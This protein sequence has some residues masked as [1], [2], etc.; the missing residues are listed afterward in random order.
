NTL[1][2]QCSLTL[3]DAT[4]RRTVDEFHR[5]IDEPRVRLTEIVDGCH[6][7]VIDAAR[8]CCL[9]IEAAHHVDVPHHAG[10]H[11][12]ER[13]PPPHLHVLGEKD[14]PH[15]ALAELLEHLIAVC[16]DGAYELVESEVRRPERRAV[17]LTEARGLRILGPALRAD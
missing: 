5:E 1:G 2:C 7:G 16:D 4:H 9:A 13:A 11:D 14:L 17:E 15:A 8:V 10:M 3:D 6:V 12:L